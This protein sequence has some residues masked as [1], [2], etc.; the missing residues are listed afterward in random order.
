[1]HEAPQQSRRVVNF[2][3]DIQF[4]PRHYYAP[5][6][7]A[8]VLE[9]LDRHAHGKVRVVGALHSWNG[10]IVSDDAI[11]NLRYFNNVEVT[12]DAD[13]T[14][15]VTAGGGCRIKDLL[16]KLHR[17]ADVTLPSLGLVT[18]QTVAGAICTATHGSG[19][20]SLSHY[21]AEV[22][23]AAYDAATGQARIYSWGE[24][25]AELRAARCALGCLGIILAVRL[26]CVP[27][28]DV[29]ESVVPCATLDDVLATEDEF[30]LQQFYLLPHRWTYLVQRRVAMSAVRPR[31]WS[32]RLYRLWWYLG[33]DIALH[34]MIKLLACVLK[35][36]RLI[37]FFYRRVL[38]HMILKN[39][40]VVDRSERMLV[41][42]HELFRHV[43]MEIFVPARHLPQAA[44]FI[45]RIVDTFDGSASQPD[46][47]L[48]LR[49][50]GLEDELL[51]YRGTFTH[52]YPITFRRVLPDDC[53]LSMTSDSDEPFYAISFI[54]YV[55]PREPFLAMASFLARGMTQLFQ[56]RLHWGKYF[57]LE[58]A[59]IEHLYPAMPEFRA[60][61]E[62]VDPNG[63]FRNRFAERVLFGSRG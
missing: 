39:T 48:A 33:T 61:C 56:A 28:Y 16:R 20:H 62:R 11:V 47:M 15:W 1:M 50:I 31:H 57:P 12:H 36:P 40:T 13:G 43:E 51:H 52:H 27:Q 29:A 8:Q 25:D 44:A 37:R 53:A 63:V 34:L 19:K 49:Q 5:T 42:E 6:T 30:P 9:L 35:S 10:G 3:R 54:T 38:S 59:D 21:V 23:V 7:E 22:R 32:A 14:A 46:D 24:D 17:F 18:E 55:E 4:T 60:L 26:R 58:R 45:R 41:M 2:G